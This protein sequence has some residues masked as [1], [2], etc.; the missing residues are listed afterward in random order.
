MSRR[1]TERGHR[2]TADMFDLQSSE[3]Q[4]SARLVR[5]LV[6]VMAARLADLEQHTNSEQSVSIIRP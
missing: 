5:E 2:R 6:S 4:R 3:A 1:A